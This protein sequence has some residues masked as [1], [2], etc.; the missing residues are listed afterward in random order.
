LTIGFGDFYPS[1]QA[2]RT[3][4]LVYALL[5][6]P[7]MTIIGKLIKYQMTDEKVQTVTSN[8]SSY[9]MEKM[10]RQRHQVYKE[11]DFEIRSLYSLVKDA[12][13]RECERVINEENSDDSTVHLP[14]HHVTERLMES[15]QQMH[16]QLQN[17]LMQKLGSDA[18]H[19][20]AAERAR[21]INREKSCDIPI[22][23][24]TDDHLEHAIIAKHLSEIG[25][26][27]GADELELLNEYRETYASI[28]AELLIAKDKLVEVEKGLRDRAPEGEW[29][30][31]ISEELE[32]LNDL[33]FDCRKTTWRTRRSSEW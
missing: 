33:N 19:V 21:Q 12:K 15:L 23:K 7:T 24:G 1:S 13:Q 2:G 6:V 9:T 27:H 25:R 5:A 32:E 14:L 4:F 18:R 28:L 29:R 16:H 8:F 17:L 10:H 26:E 11:N 20:I 31:R 22:V 30:R 3:I